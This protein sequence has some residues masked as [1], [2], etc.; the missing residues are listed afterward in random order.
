MTKKIACKNIFVSSAITWIHEPKTNI[1]AA[2][3]FLL[4]VKKKFN[5]Y[6]L[7]PIIT[8][9]NAVKN[10]ILLLHGN[11]HNQ[12]A[13]LSLAKILQKNNIGPVFTV[14]LHNGP[15]TE[16]DQWIVD[17]KV[18]SIKQQ[19]YHLGRKDVRIHLVGHSRGALLA[20]LY[21]LDQ[22]NNK[23]NVIQNWREDI[24]RIIRMGHPTTIEEK[25]I[26]AT[27]LLNSLF[28]IV[29]TR[30][31]IVTRESSLSDEQKF[32]INCGHL[33]LL[34]SKQAHQIVLNLLN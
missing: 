20:F 25:Q 29:A 28:D 32:I 6:N 18:N 16:K 8:E 11:Y 7:N 31:K 19:Y 17:E 24:G 21:S 2:L 1:K 34:Y 15:V 5:F 13:W 3:T 4:G 33:E 23:K 30:D 9:S 26:L 14:N 22:D 12:S 10:P 27:P